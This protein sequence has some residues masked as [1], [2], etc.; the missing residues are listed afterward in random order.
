[1]AFD[2][3]R[4]LIVAHRLHQLL[5]HDRT[6]GQRALRVHAGCIGRRAVAERGRR[7]T[8]MM[9]S[10]GRLAR[11]LNSTNTVEPE[12]LLRISLVC[13]RVSC[14][15]EGMYRRVAAGEPISKVA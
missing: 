7:Q 4:R 11:S 5:R 9:A 10:D 8:R 12:L 14:A 6:G 13:K 3:L 2:P 15:E 1:M